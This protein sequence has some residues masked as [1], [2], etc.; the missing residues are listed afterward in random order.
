M[1]YHHAD[2]WCFFTESLSFPEA[3]RFLDNPGIGAED[4]WVNRE[5]GRDLVSL[6]LSFFRLFSMA[7]FTACLPPSAA[8][9][10]Y[11]ALRSS[12]FF[13]AIRNHHLF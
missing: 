8:I 13:S 12:F 3:L 4:D 1:E 7:F 5:K 2:F 6:W 9:A 11:R 10:S